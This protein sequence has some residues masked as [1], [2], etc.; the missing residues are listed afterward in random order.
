MPLFYPPASGGI[1]SWV[2]VTLQKANPV[3]PGNSASVNSTNIALILSAA[4]DYSTIYFPQGTYQFSSTIAVGT[5]SFN[6]QG[7]GGAQAGSPSVIY[8][9]LCTTSA[10]ADLFALSDTYWYTTWSDI[11]FS[12]TVT[13]TAGAMLNLGTASSS[14]NVGTHVRRCNFNGSTQGSFNLFNAIVCNGTNSGNQMYVEDCNFSN[15]ASY[16]IALIGNTTTNSTGSSLIV[17]NCVMQGQLA[18]GNGLAGI[19]VT[20]AGALQIVGC[21]I[22]GF[23]NNL[24]VNPATGSPVQGCFSM[25]VLNTYFDNSFGSCIK[26]TSTGNIERCKFELCS[27]TVTGGSTAYQAVEISSTAT[28]LPT[29]IDFVNCNVYNTFSNTSTSSNGFSISG[30]QDVSIHDCRIAGWLGSG[31]TITPSASSVT[32]P[33]IQNCVIGPSGNIAANGTG[34]TLAVGSY[35]S[36]VILNNNLSGNSTAAITDS[37]TYT[38]TANNNRYLMNNLGFNPKSTVAQPTIATATTIFNSTGVNCTVYIKAVTGGTTNLT[39]CTVGGV[40]TGITA[41]LATT[42]TAYAIPV[43]ANQSISITYTS[44]P[45]WV[46]VGS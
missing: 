9:I 38:T 15:I 21:D 14:G 33:D 12:T 8:T 40:A 37:G 29:G 45:T 25:Y 3:L 28:I 5:K 35:G 11:C 42:G 23:V 16:G 39:A 1:T 41:M 2:D 22:I 31:I 43:A 6:F 10:T 17:Q 18:S 46:W 26:L 32:K 34:I 19:Q 24:L 13:K 36:Q 20:Q 27:F 4:A 30:C 7:V 44:A